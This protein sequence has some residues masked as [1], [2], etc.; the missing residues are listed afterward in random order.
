LSIVSAP[1]TPSAN[2]QAQK[3]K[4]TFRY[5]IDRSNDGPLDNTM[6][7]YGDIFVGGTKAASIK[8]NS[9]KSR[10]ARQNL[11]MGSYT[12]T[13]PSIVVNANLLDRDEATPD[14]PVFVLKGYTLNLANNVGRERTVSR[15]SGQGEAATLHMFVEKAE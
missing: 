10:E 3:Y 1:L 9:A 5:S 13:N 8:R 2:A 7:V 6:E 15:N 11:E 12:T 4:V 14:D